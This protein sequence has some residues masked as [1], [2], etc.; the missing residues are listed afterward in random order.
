MA[1]GFGAHQATTENLKMEEAPRETLGAKKEGGLNFGTKKLKIKSKDT[2]FQNKKA[3][4]NLSSLG[5]KRR[6]NV[7]LTYTSLKLT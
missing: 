4:R 2:L 1:Y 7:I 3:P 6:G 5:P